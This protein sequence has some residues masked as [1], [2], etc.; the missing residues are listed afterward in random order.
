MQISFHKIKLKDIEKQKKIVKSFFLQKPNLKKTRVNLAKIKFEENKIAE[1]EELIKN[2]VMDF[3]DDAKLKIAIANIFHD[4]HRFKLALEFLEQV[5]DIEMTFNAYRLKIKCLFALKKNDGEIAPIIK[6]LMEEYPQ[7]EEA[8]LLATDFSFRKKDYLDVVRKC[9]KI[10]SN[11]P[12][13]VR[14][15]HLLINSEYRRGNYDSTNK[16]L[17]F[18]NFVKIFYIKD[19]LKQ[20]GKSLSTFNKSLML[21]MDKFT[22]WLKNPI[23]YATTKGEQLDRL[24][25]YESSF[26]LFWEKLIQKKIE[27]YFLERYVQ[28]SE[29][30]SAVPE[31][32]KLTM[33]SWAVKLHKGGHQTPHIHAGGWISGVYYV[34]LPKLNR[35]NREGTLEFGVNSNDKTFLPLYFAQPEEGMLILFPSYMT[36]RTVPFFDDG[37]RVSI[38]FDVFQKDKHNSISLLTAGLF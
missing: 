23:R 15:V 31:N 16:L 29:Y 14:A 13:N 19:T 27:N 35:A 12:Q 5:S 24:S 26:F 32:L 7:K 20:E 36:H 2:L 18:E 17:D 3:P 10:L 33:D 34:K 38:S 28:S 37:L 9:Q 22:G 1:A 30:F 8:L 4:I 25:S 21:E 6:E 11:N